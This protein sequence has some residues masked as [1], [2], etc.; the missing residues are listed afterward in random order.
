MPLTMRRSA[1]IQVTVNNAAAAVPT[2]GLIGYWNF[3][4]GAGTTA[5]DISGSGYNGIVNGAVWGT[6]KTNSGLSFNGTT[7]YV[8]TPNISLSAFSVSTWVNSAVTT[9]AGYTRIAESA[10][11]RGLF[12]GDQQHRH[13]VQIH[14]EFRDRIDGWLRLGVRLHRRR[15]PHQRVAPGDRNLRWRDS[16]TVRG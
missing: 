16:Q 7:S 12:S 6:G 5:H 14:R 1:T 2:A 15:Y 9:Q 4:E 11:Q 8:V 10:I 13:E 3:D